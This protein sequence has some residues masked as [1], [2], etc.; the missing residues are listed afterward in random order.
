MNTK[1]MMDYYQASRT[2][3]RDGKLA[4]VMSVQKN[5][6]RDRIGFAARTAVAAGAF[7]PLAG[8]A[9]LGSSGVLAPPVA[10]AV[11][12][13][14]LFG[15]AATFAVGMVADKYKEKILNFV[16]KTKSY[17]SHIRD[18]KEHLAQVISNKEGIPKDKVF[19]EP[20]VQ[21]DKDRIVNLALEKHYE[22][23]GIGKARSL[24]GDDKYRRQ[25]DA[26]H[27]KYGDIEMSLLDA[28][29]LDNAVETFRTYLS[30]EAIS[31]FSKNANLDQAQYT[32][33]IK[34]AV[35][36]SPNME[37]ST[38]TVLKIRDGAI[39]TETMPTA[40]LS[41]SAPHKELGGDRKQGREG[42][43]AALHS[44]KPQNQELDHEGEPEAG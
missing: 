28:H 43:M 31:V 15:G 2:P 9:V 32:D 5:I 14:L 20:V 19:T 22:I 7:A 29:H 3:T 40:L 17:T 30:A 33:N 24:N 42:L 26:I 39:K 8:I 13:S 16:E 10:V 35:L 12:S 23:E 18:I 21:G 27:C 6:V 41:E 25:L 1:Q 4:Y 44:S 38:A 36:N 34:K 11:G 37:I